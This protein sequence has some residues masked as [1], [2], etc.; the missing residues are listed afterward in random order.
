MAQQLKEIDDTCTECGRE[1]EEWRLEHSNLC[2]R[3]GPPLCRGCGMDVSHMAHTSNGG[4]CIP[5]ATEAF[6]HEA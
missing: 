4:M 6:G 5:C 1:I 3:C 2:S